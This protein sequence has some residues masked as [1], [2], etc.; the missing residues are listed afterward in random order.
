M[1]L[2]A[3]GIHRPKAAS[4]SSHA[5]C[6]SMCLV[7]FDLILRRFAGVVSCLPFIPAYS[8]PTLTRAFTGVSIY[9]STTGVLVVDGLIHLQPIPATLDDLTLGPILTPLPVS[10]PPFRRVPKCYYP[11][12]R[13]NLGAVRDA[14]ASHL[15]QLSST[16]A[17]SPPLS[18][19]PL[20]AQPPHLIPS[21]PSQVL[22]KSVALK[23][24]GLGTRQRWRHLCLS[25]RII[26]GII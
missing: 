3:H 4:K 19:P 16:V 6:S 24:Y 25:M 21:S 20:P 14:S 1:S 2:A 10:L 22:A 9:T 18:P 12:P 15:T 5:A 8:F 13:F 23:A 11:C 26:L 7:S 17:V